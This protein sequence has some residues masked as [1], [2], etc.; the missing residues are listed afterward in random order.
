MELTIQDLYKIFED[1]H[2]LPISPTP[3]PINNVYQKQNFMVV[4]DIV[5]VQLNNQEIKGE[6]SNIFEKL[7]IEY[8]EIKVGTSI[9][10]IKFDDIIEHYPKNRTFEK[11]VN[12]TVLQ[13]QTKKPL[14]QPQE[15]STPKLIEV[16]KNTTKT[17]QKETPKTVE[18]V[19]DENNKK[20]PENTNFN[21]S[22]VKVIGKI[23]QF[24]SNLTIKEVVDFLAKQGIDKEKCWYF[25]TEKNNGEIHIIKNNDLGFKIQPFVISFIDL[26]IK[27]QLTENKNQ[28]KIV[29]NNQ[30]SILS[31]IPKELYDSVKNGL[32]TL[33]SQSKK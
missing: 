10:K 7:G 29:G 18:N 19:G 9:V 26:K 17:N 25:I 24:S 21:E 13:T 1:N 6:I 15:K 20:H 23:T 5:V 12:E 14:I 4:G 2:L 27:N 28:I 31:N 3:V 22:T 16:N 33:L 11:K 32:I 8:C 30:F